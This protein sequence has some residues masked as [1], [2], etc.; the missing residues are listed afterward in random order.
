M[1]GLGAVFGAVIRVYL[2]QFNGRFPWMT[3]LINTAGSLVLGLLS[4]LDTVY[5]FF[6][7]GMM[8]GFTT[9]STFALESV[10]LFDKDRLKSIQYIALSVSLPL[11]AYL[12]GWLI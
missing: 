3:L 11:L 5:L 2:S 10:Q 8:G 1:V 6:G 12:T 9:F 4:H 7:T